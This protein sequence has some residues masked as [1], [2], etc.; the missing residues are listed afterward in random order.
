MK[1]LTI[2]QFITKLIL[3]SKLWTPEEK[4]QVRDD[5]LM[6]FFGPK[7]GERVN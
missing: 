1:P 5:L 6:D 3:D 4:Q 2:E 7:P